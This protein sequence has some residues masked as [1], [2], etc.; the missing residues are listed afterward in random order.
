MVP[1]AGTTDKS[2]EVW[3]VQDSLPY[4]GDCD[5]TLPMHLDGDELPASVGILLKNEDVDLDKIEKA[6]VQDDSGN[7]EDP[8]DSE[9]PKDKVKEIQ[10]IAE[11]ASDTKVPRICFWFNYLNCLCGLC[12]YL[13]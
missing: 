4:G 3:V 12:W 11:K 8:K 10:P 6:F 1:T 5:Q 7:P 2:E 9:D 13:F